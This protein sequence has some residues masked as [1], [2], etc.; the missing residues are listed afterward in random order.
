MQDFHHDE[1]QDSLQDLSQINELKKI[2][3]KQQS[4]VFSLRQ[5]CGDLK[6]FQSRA[7][8]AELRSICV[9]LQEIT[10]A[11]DQSCEKEQKVINKQ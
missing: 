5:I 11:M 3:D 2:E 7:D 9:R 4:F 6:Q 8:N 1:H 10:N